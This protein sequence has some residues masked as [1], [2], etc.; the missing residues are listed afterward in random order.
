MTVSDTVLGTSAASNPTAQNAQSPIVA[1]RWN[2]VLRGSSAWAKQGPASRG[3]VSQI[4]AVAHRPK[5]L[6]A[7]VIAVRFAQISSCSLVM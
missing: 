5:F 6:L 2:T 1:V 4:A 7:E 3:A